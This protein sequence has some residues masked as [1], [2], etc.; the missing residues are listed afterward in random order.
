[1]SDIF[2][3]FKNN[4]NLTKWVCFAVYVITFIYAY[5]FKSGAILRILNYSTPLISPYWLWNGV[6]CLISGIIS[7]L[8]I[9]IVVKAFRYIGRFFTVPEKETFIIA[10]IAFSGANLIEGTLR[11]TYLITPL[12]YSWGYYLIGLLAGF[13]AMLWINFQLKKRYLNAGS[14]RYVF[15]WSMMAFLVLNMITTVYGGMAV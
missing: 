3:K 12:V 6:I 11:L 7:L 15:I 4:Y 10:V 9:F 14:A 2:Q 8:A 1:M 13:P 5:W